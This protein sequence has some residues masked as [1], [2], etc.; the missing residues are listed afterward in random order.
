MGTHASSVLC[1]QCDDK[2][3]LLLTRDNQQWQC[4]A[5]GQ[6]YSHKH[7]DTVVG[8]L[9]LSLDRIP[10]DN[11]TKHE[12]WLKV[13]TRILHPNHV[14]IVNVKQRLLHLYGSCLDQTS[15]NRKLELSEH[16]M[17]VMDKLDPGIT[18]WRAKILYDITRFKLVSSLQE[19]QSRKLRPEEVVRKLSECVLSLEEA[20]SGLTG[21]KFGGP[22][23]GTLKHRIES[24]SRAKLL[25]D[26]YKMLLTT[27]LKLPFIK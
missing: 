18:A 20:V 23:T 14:L 25:G 19:L 9:K 15:V 8:K 4:S 22:K 1:H 12:A 27:C 21:D 2:G 26:G 6:L 13:A 10:S 16:V 17:S 24:L 3:A 11:V 5:C 7:V